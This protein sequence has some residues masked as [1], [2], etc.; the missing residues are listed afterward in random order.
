MEIYSLWEPDGSVLRYIGKAR[1]SKQRL[2]SHIRD[3]PIRNTPVYGWIRRLLA[4]GKSP[5]LKI[6]EVCEDD[7]WQSRERKYI[8][9]ERLHNIHLLNVASGGNEPFCPTE[10][11]AA[12]GRK[13]AK[14]RT[15]TL[16]NAKIYRLK[17]NIG[18]AL[19]SGYVS[20]KAK[21]KL[22][23]AAAIAPNLFGKWACLT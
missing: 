13:T 10:T 20:E 16:R 9:I 7:I 5:L 8:A 15:R 22:R 23:L 11:R 12:N 18:R 19:R 17:R 4:E 6:I 14:E 3:A 2:K 1:C 21:D